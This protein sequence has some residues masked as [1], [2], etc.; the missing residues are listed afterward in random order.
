MPIVIVLALSAALALVFLI[1]IYNGL[2]S[3]RARVQESW[4]GVD[5]ELQRRHDLIP[6][7]VESVRGYM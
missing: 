2:V 4:S 1:A 5:T 6:N 7:L 3:A